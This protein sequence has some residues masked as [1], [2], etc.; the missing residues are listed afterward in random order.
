MKSKTKL[1]K[2]S[3]FLII[4]GSVLVLVVVVLLFLLH[5]I[6]K[7]YEEGIPDTAMEKIMDKFNADNIGE[8]LTSENSGMSEFESMENISAYLKNSMEGKN[9]TF[10]RKNGEYTNNTPVYSI[11]ADDKVFAKVKLASDG[12][13]GHK[14]TLWKLGE[15]AFEGLN[16]N[17][18][19]IVILA[20]QQA[21]IKVNGK[22]VGADYVAESDIIV[23]I[24]KNVGAYTAVPTNKKI[25]IKG[26]F[27][28]P[29]IT[30]TLNGKTITG[31][32]DGN[33]YTIP[34][35]GDESLVATIT[36]HALTSSRSY[37]K[38]I[39]NR[40]NKAVMQSYMVGNAKK[41]VDDIPAVWAFMYGIPFTYEFQNESVTDIVKYSDTCVS[42]KVHY[43][44]HINWNAGHK[45]YDT[46]LV[47][48][49][50]YTNNGWYLADFV[51]L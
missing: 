42:C 19:E 10:K 8:L 28:Q 46:D 15:V 37:G 38:Y 18:D 45:V 25:G 36:E 23:D 39:I 32:W 27:V 21:D 44:L 13:N 3:K 26:F 49:F 20:P 17:S 22:E 12:V 33:T 16:Q 1:G 34:Y 9:I 31:T 40:G 7:D 50:V 24:C 11:L 5:G 48:T 43:D 47:Y 29:E 14:F 41:L 30:A 6:L 51:I 2:F 4:Y 35:P